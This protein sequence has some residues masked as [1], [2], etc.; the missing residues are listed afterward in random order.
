MYGLV[1]NGVTSAYL[2]SKTNQK[3]SKRF[4]RV[5]IGLLDT[6]GEERWSRVR[7]KMKAMGLDPDTTRGVLSTLYPEDLFYSRNCI[8]II[9]GIH[10]K[11]N[12]TKASVGNKSHSIL[13]EIFLKYGPDRAALFLTE[14]TKITDEWLCEIGFSI[15]LD[16]FLCIQ[17][18]PCTIPMR[19]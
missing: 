7:Q 18:G 13:Y 19:R 11:G 10:V 16:D 4:M 12:L 17:Y 3:V 5:L 6:D 2:M 8:E 14:A 15:D 9:H 1:I